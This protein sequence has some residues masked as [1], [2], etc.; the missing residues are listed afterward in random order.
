MIKVVAPAQHH[1]TNRSLAEFHQYWGETHGP[2]FANTANL[3]RYVQHLTLPEAYGGDPAP[4]FDGVSMFW[5]DELATEFAPAGDREAFELVR[6]VLGTTPGGV[7]PTSDPPAH[8]DPDAALVRAVLKDDVQLFDR[9]LGWPMNTKRAFVAARERV[10]LEGATAPTMVKAIFIVSKLSGLTLSEFFA[11]WEHVLGP[12][13]AA[14][15]GLRRYVQ[16]HAIPGAY[17][18]AGHTHDGWSELWFDDLLA[19]RSALASQQWQAVR[20]E[21]E[22]LFARP[23]GVGVARERVQKDLDWV[24]NDWGAGAMEPRKIRQRLT[25]DGYAELAADAGAPAKLK[26]AAEHGALAV[27]THA[28]LVTIDESHIDVRPQP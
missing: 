12:L 10:I 1:P 11:R 14:T 19:L 7:A 20:A 2:L 16:N 13:T 25:R 6:A 26:R 24:Y 21:A 5:Y 22:M 27:W 15:P 28:H 18:G 9:S 17:A 4:T 23:I 8:E 3:R